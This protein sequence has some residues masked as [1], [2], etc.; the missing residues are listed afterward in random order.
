MSLVLQ[1]PEEPTDGT[2]AF[3]N[4]MVLAKFIAGLLVSQ[5][6]MHVDPKLFSVSVERAHSSLE[7]LGRVGT[8]TKV[9]MLS[10]IGEKRP[11]L[12][13]FTKPCVTTEIGDSEAWGNVQKRIEKI[14]KSKMV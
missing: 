13:A 11:L 10:V 3:S 14:L 7:K 9:E 1:E 12:D 8:T 4:A 5:K 2:A 6:P